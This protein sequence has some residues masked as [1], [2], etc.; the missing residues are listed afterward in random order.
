MGRNVFAH[1]SGIHVKGMLADTST[2]EPYSPDEVGGTRRYVLGKHSGLALVNAVL[3]Q[4]GLAPEEETSRKCLSEV[5]ALAVR[6]GGVVE[7]G[8]LIEMYRRLSATGT[9]ND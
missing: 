5:R 3:E 1:E 2:F 9:H 8:E 7:P 4:H 6:H